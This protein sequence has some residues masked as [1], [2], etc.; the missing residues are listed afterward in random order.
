M[1]SVTVVEDLAIVILTIV[2]TGLGNAGKLNPM[3][4]LWQ[5]GKAVLLLAPIVF[6]AWKGMPRL[7]AH[8][9]TTGNEEISALV[10]LA[11]CLTA[12]A[13]T[14]ALGLSLALGA[15][16]GGLLLGSCRD[17]H[18]LA[19]K[20]FPK[21]DVFV[22]LFFITVGMI[23]DPRALF[24]DWRAL[25]VILGL[26]LVG[27][28]AIWFAVVR[29]FGYRA[30][31]AFRV[32]IGLTQVGELSFILASVAL[33]VGRI[34]ESVYNAALAASLLDFVQCAAVQVHPD[35]AGGAARWR[36]DSCVRRCQ[37]LAASSAN[38]AVGQFRRSFSPG[39]R[40]TA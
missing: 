18:E 21:R 32:G 9:K 26:I 15:F 20:I 6:V 29:L 3:E 30:Q 23:I 28:F 16:A 33:R 2:L 5:I 39:T 24:A 8:V 40:R 37:P 35:L 10:V 34:T 17:A 12:A 14:E 11:V 27:K 13:T 38:H 36:R 1:V 7:L 25:A 31:T 4:I 22:A 19:A